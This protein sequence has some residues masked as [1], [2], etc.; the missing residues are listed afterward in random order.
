MLENFKMLSVNQLNANIKLMEIWKALNVVDYPLMV[1]R[2]E[3]KP[4]NR[5]TRADTSGRPREIGKSLLAQKTSVSNAIYI[6]N[7]APDSVK[8]CNSLYQAKK[9]IRSYCNSLPI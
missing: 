8:M 6:W 7:R 5:V 1:P 9:E 2:Q 3:I 4:E